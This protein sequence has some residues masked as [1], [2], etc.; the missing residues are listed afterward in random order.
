MRAMLWEPLS[1]EDV[2]CRL[3]AH[4][5]RLKKGGKGLCG[6]RVNTGGEL[7]SM[8]ADVVTGIQMDPVEKKPLY[9]FLPGSKTF[10][11]GSAG[12]NFQCRFC[13]NH[14]IARVPSSGVVPGR[15]ITPDELTHLAEKQQARSIAFTYNEPTVF[16]EQ[17]YETSALAQAMGLRVILVSNGFMGEDFLP[18][19]RNRVDA[20]N[21]D[22]KSFSDDF[23][24]D[25]CGGR[26]QPVLDNLKTIRA[27]GWWL[28]VTTLVIPGCNDS[29]A[30]LRD[31]AAFVRDELG[32]DTP[33]HLTA[34]HGAYR[35]AGHPSTPL[36]RLEDAWRI[37]RE[38]GL[39]FVYM[40][41]AA[42]AMGGTTFCP[43][44]GAPVIERRGRQT[45]LLGGPGRCPA[46]N[47]ALPGVWK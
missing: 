12:C 23:Y 30:E 43:S 1:G 27:M 18:S 17:V 39:H 25:Y 4:A 35:M 40:G 2:R 34:F 16:F 46:C 6:V 38:A 7:L 10:S 31:M 5:C 21:V 11:V 22:L 26:L 14:H 28:E 41:N 15:R 19:L 42:T 37:G 9:H 3:C 44:C 32:P 47:A 8:V 20:I 24:R 13:Q 36:S 33:W 45:R 29:D